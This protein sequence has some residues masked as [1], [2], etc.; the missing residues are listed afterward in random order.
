M[1]QN[2]HY[3]NSH[4][5]RP[6]PQ[7]QHCSTQTRSL[8]HRFRTFPNGRARNHCKSNFGG[9]MHLDATLRSASIIFVCIIRMHILFIWL[10]QWRRHTP[11]LH[12]PVGRDGGVSS[13]QIKATRRGASTLPRLGPKML[14]NF[15]FSGTLAAP[16]KH[17]AVQAHSNSAQIEPPAQSTKCNPA[18]TDC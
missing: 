4:L 17:R 9:A 18:F 13:G 3:I 2:A 16:R 12:P 1:P 5:T 15:H 8:E 7:T 14:L 11:Q 6:F 10:G